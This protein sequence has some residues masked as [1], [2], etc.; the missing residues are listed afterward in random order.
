[1]NAAAYYQDDSSP[2]GLLPQDPIG[3]H[4]LH[5][6]HHGWSFIEA[7][8][9]EWGERP[10]WRTERRYP[11]ELRNLWS[12]YKNEEMLL[13]LSFGSQTNYLLLDIDRKSGNHPERDAG[14]FKGILEALEEDTG[15]CRYVPIQSS[16]S[17]GL[18]IYYFLPEQVHSFTLTSTVKQT[19]NKAG[20]QLRDGQLEVYPNPKPWNPAKP[21]NFRSH[22]LPLQRGSFLL[23]SDLEPFSSSIETLLDWADWSASGQDVETLTLAMQT[24]KVVYQK[25]F[26][27]NHG[28]ISAEEFC[29][30]LQEV[31]GQGW[32]SYGQTNGL[33]LTF[34][35]Y[36]IIFLA[37]SGEELVEYM[38]ETALN[39]PGYR[40]FCRHQHEIERR[41]RERAVSA[42][43][44]PYYPY[45][46]K[47]PRTKTY[48][49]QFYGE[50]GQVIPFPQ[51][52]VQDETIG[53][54]KAT[55][56]MLKAEG[57]FPDGVYKRI[58]AMIEQSNLA[59][60]KG[61]SQSTLYKEEY[62]PLW[63]PAY[64][65]VET[66]LVKEGVNPDSTE[67]KYP[68]LPDPWL[69]EIEPS[70]PVISSALASLHHF[71]IYEGLCLP[72]VKAGGCEVITAPQSHLEPKDESIA[73][74]GDFQ[75]HL[76]TLVFTVSTILYFSLQS[77]TVSHPQFN[78]FSG[79][80]Y[81]PFSSL[82]LIDKNFQ[83][84]YVAAAK[85]EKRE[86]PD[87]Q[88]LSIGQ[89]ALLICTDPPPSGETFW[90]SR[91]DS[92][93][94]SGGA[95]RGD[96]KGDSRG[97]SGTC[98]VGINS[99]I[100]PSIPVSIPPQ[101]TAPIGSYRYPTTKSSLLPA[102]STPN[103]LPCSLLVFLPVARLVPSVKPFAEAI[104]T[105]DV[106]T[107]SPPAPVY[108]EQ[109]HREAIRFRLQALPKA[110][111]LVRVFCNS[112]GI[113][114]MPSLRQ[115]MEQFLW[116]YLM[117]RHPSLIL[118]EQTVAWFAAHEELTAQIKSFTLFWEY[119]QN[120][121]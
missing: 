23:D 65:V 77:D 13:G 91:G 4:F 79:K 11:L 2:R 5:Y 42:E 47:P 117:Q 35:K 119:L 21:T 71:A 16:E 30:Q 6:F 104:N 78:F 1:M 34:A 17:G 116:Y 39:S 87:K 109:Q 99:S 43:N 58:R 9:P 52:Q 15:L 25:Q 98:R 31:I 44:Y 26:Y 86:I 20:F 67:Q 10:N 88:P 101:A 83:Y 114:P 38:L 80:E 90:D 102:T 103:F 81:K 111:Q 96:S 32:T 94:D 97:D 29:F 19:L 113:Y 95:T 54:I 18:H 84:P 59:F 37:L 74:D 82:I 68:I 75:N 62:K 112:E 100:P 110:K 73:A 108:T 22:R 41:V 89:T 69:E 60:E 12:K 27:E 55:I 49:E 33:L 50:R 118:Q 115:D 48:K 24:A 106:P 121:Q 120:L 28:K 107:T 7:P 63:H 92:N 46:G 56:A 3:Q 70:K 76:E 72:P 105:V 36:G 66:E 14:R 57:K 51:K 64:E 85:P 61:V 93:L 53:R 8:T 40:Q 45:A